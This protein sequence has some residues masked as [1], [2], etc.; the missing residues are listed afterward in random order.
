MGDFVFSIVANAI[1]IN[2]HRHFSTMR[3]IER[4]TLSA[5]QEG[6]DFR[7]ANTEVVHDYRGEGG[8]R[9]TSVKL[10]GNT[11]ATIYPDR[12]EACDCGEQTQTTKSR[13]NAIL[14]LCGDHAGFNQRQFNWYR[15]DNGELVAPGSVQTFA[16]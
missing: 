8:L 4:W 11:I 13:L 10:Y 15:K 3:A 6:K 9:K 1:D 5:I 12:I 16:R 14:M 2:T 7:R